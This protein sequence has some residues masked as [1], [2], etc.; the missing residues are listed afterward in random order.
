[1]R[2]LTR[3]VSKYTCK[4]NT[5]IGPRKSFILLALFSLT[6]MVCGPSGETEPY[7]RSDEVLNQGLSM[8]AE[9]L[10]DPQSLKRYDPSLDVNPRYLHPE[11]G[12]HSDYEEWR[13]FRAEY[14]DSIDCLYNYQRLTLGRTTAEDPLSAPLILDRWVRTVTRA[15]TLADL[16]ETSSR[17]ADLS[18]SILGEA[19]PPLEHSEPDWTAPSPLLARVDSAARAANEILLE[20]ALGGL[21]ENVRNLLPFLVRFTTKTGGSYRPVAQ[22]APRYNWGLCDGYL[23]DQSVKYA[24]YFEPGS[25]ETPQGLDIPPGIPSATS[26]YHLFR[27]LTGDLHTTT[28]LWGDK[29]WSGEHADF[30][31]QKVHVVGMVNAF[32]VLTPVLKSRFLKRLKKELEQT[33]ELQAKDKVEG[34]T[35]EVVLYRHTAYGDLLVGGPGPNRYDGVQASV[36]IDL[37]GDD[38]YETDYDL[39][40]LGR[41]PLRLLIDLGGND[42]YSHQ[43]PV[44]PGGGVFGLGVL[45]D[46]RGDDIYAQGTDPSL[47]R[48]RNT[49]WVQD[50]DSRSRAR[51]VDPAK[52][53]GGSEPASLDG[54][55]S[56]GAAYFGIGVHVDRAGNDTYLVDKWALGAAYGPGIGI[57]SDEAGNDW[58]V[59]AIQSIGIGFNKGVGILRD[60][61]EGEDLYQSWGVYRS[62]YN[63]PGG[64]DMGFT[65]FGIG[66]G[67]CWRGEVFTG[68]NWPTYAGG[69]GL[70][71][72]D[73]GSDIYV[74]STFGLGNGFSSGIGMVV[75]DAGDDVYLAMKAD[76]DKH[77]G[78]GEGIHHGVGMLLDRS[79]NDFYSGGATSASGW[80]LGAGFLVDVSGNDTYTDIHHL[81]FKPAHARVQSLAVFLDGAGADSISEWSSDWADATFFYPSVHEGMGGN[82]SF[83]LL[84]GASATSFPPELSSHLGRPVSLTPVSWGIEADGNEYPRGL[85]VIMSTAAQESGS[86]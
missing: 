61:G 55:F 62:Q 18:V 3:L 60:K 85:G 19:V 73:G 37:G 14:E 12:V 63:R 44:G 69:L 33:P 40:R 30:G 48:D 23:E 6:V 68:T 9:A 47:A 70:V 34:V 28:G 4:I 24:R 26:V 77:S 64:P 41:Y 32:K 57:L 8:I 76:E 15:A 54:G 84:L 20:E 71:N 1:M 75:D 22:E 78:L 50:L 65:G 81:G 35:G 83:A 38:R 25:S 56:Y 16:I 45:I 80:D 17:T 2:S 46:E 74:G 49:L 13:N 29:G 5:L 43:S 82:F 27:S 67:S 79:G 59:A 21:D 58:Y 7:H 11:Y 42:I 39:S 66:V 10:K 86:Q 52:V 51:W 31:N 72:D 36:I 53:Y